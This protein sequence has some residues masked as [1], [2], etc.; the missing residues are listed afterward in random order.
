MHHIK[1]INR[2]SIMATSLK[3]PSSHLSGLNLEKYHNEKEKEI[4]TKIGQST[5]PR[6]LQIKRN[7]SYN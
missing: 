5:H 3:V 4:N 7:T 6:D 2:S 1:V